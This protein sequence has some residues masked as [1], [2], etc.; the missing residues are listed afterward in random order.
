MK[1][2]ILIVLILAIT[3][4]GDERSPES[5]VQTNNIEIQPILIKENI[6][7][8]LSVNSSINVSM[9]SLK[10]RSFQ[11]DKEYVFF[12]ISSK[13]IITNYTDSFS[14]L[15][16]YMPIIINPFKEDIPDTINFA[17]Y[18][19]ELVKYS[20]H[21][22]SAEEITF[23]KNNAGKIKVLCKVPRGNFAHY[24]VSNL[25]PLN[26]SKTDIIS[27]PNNERKSTIIIRNLNEIFFNGVILFMNDTLFDLNETG[28]R[29]NE[30]FYL[31]DVLVYND[32]EFLYSLSRDNNSIKLKNGN[33]LKSEN[34][35]MA[36]LFPVANKIFFTSDNEKMEIGNGKVSIL[37]AYDVSTGTSKKYVLPVWTNQF[38]FVDEGFYID[39]TFDLE[40]RV[41]KKSHTSDS[42]TYGFIAY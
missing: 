13:Q 10:K 15:E 42:W 11:L 39:Y 35:L 28:Y 6:D 7:S 2:S 37:Y 38:Y 9:D 3:S 25:Y 17:H 19:F 33:V 30:E 18:A 32:K 41:A 29:G 24:S 27:V 36:E 20:H 4:C 34:C 5:K 16:T 22:I 26:K 14:G 40:I 21:G 23:I 12:P 8:I 1:A 31:Y